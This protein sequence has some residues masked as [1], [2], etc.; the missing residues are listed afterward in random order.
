MKVHI[1]Q[2]IP[3]D[4]LISELGLQALVFQPVSF[5]LHS[6]CENDATH[7]YVLR[8]RVTLPHNL[9]KLLNFKRMKF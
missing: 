2:K 8:G 7:W 3:I 5:K 6:K 9:A 4:R 1:I